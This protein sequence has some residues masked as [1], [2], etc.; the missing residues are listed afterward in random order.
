[1]AGTTTKTF[2]H[3]GGDE[4]ESSGPVTP[5]ENEEAIESEDTSILNSLFGHE[6]P[7]SL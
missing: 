2:G 4:S 5:T 6:S 7:Q 1:V 3:N